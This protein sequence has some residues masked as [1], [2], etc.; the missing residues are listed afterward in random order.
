MAEQSIS[1][2]LESVETPGIQ[3]QRPIMGSWPM[4][5]PDAQDT[6]CCSLTEARLV[7]AYLALFLLPWQGG[8][9]SIRLARFGAYEVRIVEFAQDLAGEGFP[10]W[11]ELYAHDVQASLDSCGCG[12]LEDAVDAADEFMERASALHL[13]QAVRPVG[14]RSRS[15]R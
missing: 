11:L 2:H 7:R 5:G 12:A 6:V 3:E 14:V 15:P 1:P 10:L 9:R 4:R 13:L 8:T